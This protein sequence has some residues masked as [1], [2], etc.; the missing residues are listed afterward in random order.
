MNTRIRIITALLGL[1]SVSIFVVSFF[2]FAALSQNFDIAGDYISKL[3]AEG[4]AYASWWNVIG[5]ATVGIVLA[6]FGWFFGLS[7][8]DRVLGVCLMVSGIGFALAAIPTDFNDAHSALSKAHYAS[9]CFSLAGWCCGLARLFGE[10]SASDFAQTTASYSVVLAL[11]PMICIGGGVSAEP[12]AHRIVLV[13]VFAW[14]VLNS[15]QLLRPDFSKRI[16]RS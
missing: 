12:I 2:L 7:R 4:Q 3:G 6:T 5:F 15:I 9:I 8:K 1:S 14:I 13:V 10:R 16:E 11:L